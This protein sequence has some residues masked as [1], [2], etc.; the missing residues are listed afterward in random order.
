M[1]RPSTS[2]TCRP[3]SRRAWCAAS[4]TPVLRKCATSAARSRS[5]PA[6]RTERLSGGVLNRTASTLECTMNLTQL[7]LAELDREGPRTRRALEQVPI[8]RDDWKPHPKSMPLARLAGLVASMPSWV[9]LVIDQDDLE[10]NPAAGGQYQQPSIDQLV[11][12][13]DGHVRKA[14]E[15]LSRTS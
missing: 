4:V 3:S 2:I 15:S 9:T 10:L 8:G 1:S 13:H 11:D 14:R 5:P 6:A 12:L 7:F